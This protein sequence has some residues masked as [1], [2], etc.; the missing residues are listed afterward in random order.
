MPF[1]KRNDEGEVIAVSGDPGPDFAEEVMDDDPLLA[2]FLQGMGGD[3]ATLEAS[4]LDLIR[5][6]EDVVELLV[7][8]GVILF[9]ELPQDAQQKIMRRKHLRARVSNLSNLIDDD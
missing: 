4:D 7:D 3:A 9:T 2:Q 5:V 8:K 1:V 6:L